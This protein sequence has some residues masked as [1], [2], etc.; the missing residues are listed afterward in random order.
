[1]HFCIATLVATV[2]RNI[3]AESTTTASAPSFSSKPT[4]NN[5]ASN[6]NKKSR[7]AAGSSSSSL[8]T[9]FSTSTEQDFQTV[10]SR[11][12]KVARRRDTNKK[13]GKNSFVI[14]YPNEPEASINNVL[15]EGKSNEFFSPIS[16][17]EQADDADY[18][19]E[20]MDFE[21]KHRSRHSRD[22]SDDSDDGEYGKDSEKGALYDAYNLL[23]TLAQVNTMKN[24][25][26]F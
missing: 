20:G 16:F 8:N 25:L 23:H 1:M 13:K 12:P 22:D 5:N 15:K 21:D 7:Q 2:A 18:E 24:S 17:Y 9:K 4:L 11:R 19:D 26:S 6:N 10:Q 3:N 14:D